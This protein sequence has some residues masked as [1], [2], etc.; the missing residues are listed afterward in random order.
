MHENY[1]KNVENVHFS[2]LFFPILFS[3]RCLKAA[4]KVNNQKKVTLA[5]KKYEKKKIHV[6]HPNI[7]CPYSMAGIPL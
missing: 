4:K 6:N 1:L 3:Q 5:F 2:F 7:T